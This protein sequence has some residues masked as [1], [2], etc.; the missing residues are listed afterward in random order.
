[1]SVHPDHVCGSS[2]WGFDHTGA[3]G[4]LAEKC[5]SLIVKAN[6]S[7]INLHQHL[8]PN[9]EQSKLATDLGDIFL[10]IIAQRMLREFWQMPKYR[11][12]EQALKAWY[13]FARD[14]NWKNPHDV[15]KQFA[16]ASII[17]NRRVVF[18]IAG[19]KYRLIVHFH[20]N[21]AIGYVRFVGTHKQY[22]KI[23][24]ESI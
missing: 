17:G 23:D 15:K 10:R 1:L 19:N 14:A 11:D 4:Y 22:D 12:S 3:S 16:T 8:F 5:E 18:N 7:Y 21:T 9:R 6:E 13:A 20:F 24:A 2:G